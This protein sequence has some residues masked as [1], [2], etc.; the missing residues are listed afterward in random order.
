MRLL[1]A[2]A[3]S[4]KGGAENFFLR[5]VPAL[6]PYATQ[7]VLIR[8]HAGRLEELN[9]QGIPGTSIAFGGVFDVKSRMLFFKEI[10]HFSPHIVL[11]WMSRATQFCPSHSLIR[12]CLP[13]FLHVGRLG[14]FYDLKYYKH[15]DAL[16]G[17]TKGVVDYILRQGWPSSRVFYLPNFARIP[18]SIFPCNR[19][20]YNTPQTV[21]LILGVGRLHRNKAFDTLIR[22]LTKVSDAYLW[23]LGDGP[24]REKLEYL[25][26]DLGLAPRVRFIGWHEDP[27]SFYGACDLFVCPSRHEPLGNVILEAW[28]HKKPIIAANSQ[29]PKE[30]IEDR[31]TGF[32][33]PIDDVGALASLMVE[34]LED[35]E[36][37]ED[38]AQQGYTF[39]A[40]N[41]SQSIVVK[42]YLE[43]FEKLLRT[44]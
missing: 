21:P 26:E 18:D 23:L 30:L 12:K 27:S 31:I 33:F 2:M 9:T 40:E 22:A 4:S 25:A 28:A 41:F 13:S 24:E 17:N 14:G 6:S 35:K 8:D 16:I 7:R 42:Y 34:C 37:R 44:R 32:L 15:C 36:L 20:I 1:Q 5:L 3:G 10:K 11:T 39:M 29:G 43:C 38:V 19:K